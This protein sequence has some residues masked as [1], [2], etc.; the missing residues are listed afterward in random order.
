[1]QLVIFDIVRNHISRVALSKD[2]VQVPAVEET[3]KVPIASVSAS[4]ARPAQ[5]DII[6]CDAHCHRAQS[7]RI[8][9]QQPHGQ[10]WWAALENFENLD[11]WC[12]LSCGV[13]KVTDDPRLVDGDPF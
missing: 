11:S 6:K 12:M 10:T 9:R 7:L 3:I 8:L 13:S 4:R 5:K 2:G 1:M